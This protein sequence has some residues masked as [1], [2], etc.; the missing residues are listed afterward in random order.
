M[1]SEFN[2]IYVIESLDAANET[3]TGTNLYNDVLQHFSAKYSD[4]DAQLFSVDTKAELLAAFAE[5]AKQCKAGIKPIVHLEIHGLEDKSGLALNKGYIEWEELYNHLSSINAASGWNL[6][7]TMA[8]CYG[9]YAMKLIKPNNP[10]PFAGIFGSFDALSIYGLE[11][12]YNAFYQELYNSLDFDA[13]LA[14]LQ[15]ANPSLE[16]YRL[17]VPSKHL[18]T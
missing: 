15:A 5:I 13:A 4:K 6:Y 18:K 2:K 14:A 3:L 12:S 8:V 10:A 9:N 1:P 17:I 16:E 7:L 11:I